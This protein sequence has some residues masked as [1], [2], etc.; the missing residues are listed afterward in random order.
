[1][2]NQSLSRSKD[3]SARNWASRS[4]DQARSTSASAP[5]GYRVT[6]TTTP[7]ELIKKD[8]LREH[9]RKRSRE[10]VGS[11]PIIF[12]ATSTGLLV[13]EFETGEEAKI[14]DALTKAVQDTKF[15][16]FWIF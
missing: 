1:M 16:G 13:L 3:C 5:T 7:R 4:S 9:I 11:L 2:G 8:K 14:V 12:P 15:K 10:I 6:L